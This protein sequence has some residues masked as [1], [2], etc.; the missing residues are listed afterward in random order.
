MEKQNVA[1]IVAT[2]VCSLGKQGR[3]RVIENHLSLQHSSP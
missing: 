1:N 2:F 3:F